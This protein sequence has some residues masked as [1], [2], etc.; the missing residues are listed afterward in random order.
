MQTPLPTGWPQTCEATFVA[1]SVKLVMH[2]PSVQ[3]AVVVQRWEQKPINPSA[4]AVPPSARLTHRIQLAAH[5][6]A[7]VAQLPAL[8][9]A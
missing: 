1:R 7:Q 6:S 4:H 3:S 9:Q 8:L 5:T 2:C